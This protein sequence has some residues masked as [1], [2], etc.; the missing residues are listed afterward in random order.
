[1][2]FRMEE[3]SVSNLDL[4]IKN[5]EEKFKDKLNSNNFY[6]KF[7][8]ENLDYYFIYGKSINDILSLFSEFLN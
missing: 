2:K 4:L 1:M 3:M 7:V 6:V 8:R 5:K